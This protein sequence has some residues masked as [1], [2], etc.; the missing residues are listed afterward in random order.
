MKACEKGLSRGAL[1]R[2]LGDVEF[3]S[4]AC[5]CHWLIKELVCAYSRAIGKQSY[6]GKTKLNVGRRKAESREISHVV[7]P[8]PEGFLPGKQQ[9]CGDTQITKNGLN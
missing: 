9:P 1:H 3:P 2:G 4:V 5:E 6:V 7:L 8:E